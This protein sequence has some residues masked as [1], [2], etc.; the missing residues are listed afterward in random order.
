MTLAQNESAKVQAPQTDEE[1]IDSIGAR[2]GYHVSPGARARAL[3]QSG[4]IGKVPGCLHFPEVRQVVGIGIRPDRQQEDAFAGRAAGARGPQ[5]DRGEIG[6]AFLR[7]LRPG[8]TNRLSFRAGSRLRRGLDRTGDGPVHIVARATAQIAA[9]DPAGG[10]VGLFDP[11]PAAL[12]I[13]H[14]NLLI[15][16]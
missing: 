8:R 11:D 9:I 15:G 16:L 5:P 6:G 14:G 10:A 7:A 4:E 3:G 2:S 1:I 12:S 13:Q